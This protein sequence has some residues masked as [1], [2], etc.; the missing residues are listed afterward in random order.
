MKNRVV[1]SCKKKEYDLKL[2]PKIVANNFANFC[3]C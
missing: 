3:F 2:K 1:N